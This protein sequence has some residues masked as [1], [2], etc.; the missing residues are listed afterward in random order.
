MTTPANALTAALDC[1]QR[2]DE[3]RLAR[4]GKVTASAITDVLAKG[5][6]K[7]TEAITRVNYRAKLIAEILTG[8]PVE[9]EFVSFKMQ[10]GID[11]EPFARAAYELE[12]DTTIE[13]VGFVLHPRIE[14]FGA[15]PDGLVGP[16]GLVQI[17]CPNTA[18]HLNYLLKGE[19]PTEYQPQMLVE[20]VCANRQWCDFVSF[21]PRLPKYLQLFVRRFQRDDARIAEIETK[22]EEFLDE[23][24]D[25]LVRLSSLGDDMEAILRASVEKVKAQ[26]RPRPA[27]V[28]AIDEERESALT[29]D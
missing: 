19:V 27:I 2:S 13:S 25:M 7:G 14:C 12:Q 3:W 8:R 22:V 4:S 15:S 10:W 18:T 9:D 5:K 28:V 21:D 26:K 1:E 24:Q 20:M 29:G 11:T 23:V 16:D 6:T 17:K